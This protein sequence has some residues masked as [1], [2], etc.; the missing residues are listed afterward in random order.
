M[1]PNRLTDSNAAFPLGYLFRNALEPGVST[2]IHL[3]GRATLVPGFMK[4][5]DAGHARF[6]KVPFADLFAPSIRL[7]EEGILFNAGLVRNIEFRSNVISR[8]PQTKAMFTRED[9]EFY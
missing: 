2:E 8:R 7:A 6:G 1:N 9:G 5:V 4:G 3:S